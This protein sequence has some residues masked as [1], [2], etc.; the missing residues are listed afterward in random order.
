MEIDSETATLFD[1]TSDPIVNTVLTDVTDPKL[2]AP[3]TEALDPV[4]S[5][6]LIEAVPRVIALP[7]IDKCDP[8]CVFDPTDKPEDTTQLP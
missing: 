5:P 4:T 6:S 8:I 3:H 7:D 2:H 1:L